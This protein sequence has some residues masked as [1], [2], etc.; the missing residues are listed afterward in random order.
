MTNEQKSL[1]ELLEPVKRGK[2]SATK[3]PAPK[4]TDELTP[5]ELSRRALMGA[6]DE[7]RHDVDEHDLQALITGDLASSLPSYHDN[8]D[9]TP[10]ESPPPGTRYRLTDA[11]TLIAVELLRAVRATTT[12]RDELFRTITDRVRAERDA[13]KGGAR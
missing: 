3:T 5:A 13:E 2:K 7:I 12:Q 9:H 11:E 1:D 6:L 10:H 8:A 4:K